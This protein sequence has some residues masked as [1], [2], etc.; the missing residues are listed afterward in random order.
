MTING[1]TE[2]LSPYQNQ[3]SMIRNQI[4]QTVSSIKPHDIQEKEDI[5]FVRQWISS[6]A[7]IFRISKPDNPKTH[8]VSYF[9]LVDQ[10]ANEVLL[11]DHKSAKL[12]L[13]SGGHVELNEHPSDT[14]KRE[15]IEELGIKA[16][17][18]FD[19]PL[20][21][22]IN[23][24]S[25]EDLSQH[26]DVSL[27]YV[28]KG[29]KKDVLV[30][31][32]S[33]FHGIQWF[34]WEDIPF[35]HTDPNMNRFMSKVLKKLST[36]NSYDLSAEEYELNTKS[37]HPHED[38]KF[39][40]SMLP[41]QAKIMDLGCGPG[42]DAKIFSEM[43]CEVFGI[44]F[45]SKMIEIAQKNVPNATFLI[46][47]IESIDFPA[48][49]FEGIWASAALLHIPKSNMALVFNKI[50]S[51]LKK[52]GILYISVKENTIDECLEPDHRYKGL[53][54]FWSFFQQNELITLLQ[55]AGFTILKSNI[56]DKTHHY[57][58]HPLIK[59]FAKK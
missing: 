13:P 44:D 45:S 23:T 18:L 29:S 59:I 57:Q 48:E 25:S 46:K 31:D 33:E 24:T 28:L 12:W 58:T 2:A 16:N 11:V 30:F 3:S 26:V 55:N 22:T 52:E 6:G 27:W 49:T 17:F 4:Y 42:R 47:D 14:V 40:F 36:L 19:E 15:I 39:F 7:E 8:L 32:E 35:D 37:L 1:R 51:F 53:K 38:G 21:L 9:I 50:Y 20:F 5:E 54:K 10:E 43:G 56:H 41:K 34:R